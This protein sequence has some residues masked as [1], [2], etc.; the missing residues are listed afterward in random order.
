MKKLF[1][2]LMA[3]M[4]CVSIESFAQEVRGVETKLVIYNGPEYKGLD[5]SPYYR[6]AKSYYSTK[7]FGFSFYNM[8]TIPISVD[9]VLYYGG[10]IVD[11]KSFVLKSNESYIWKQEDRFDFKVNV[12][13]YNNDYARWIEDGRISPGDYRVEYKAFKLQ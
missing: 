2:I 1:F 5:R 11:S 8:N 12:Y 13:W 10:N 6:D 7:W 4:S 3:V 9:A